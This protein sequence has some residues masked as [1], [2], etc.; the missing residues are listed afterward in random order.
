MAV[1]DRAPAVAPEGTLDPAEYADLLTLLHRGRSSGMLTIFRG[2]AA[3]KVYFGSG[4][5]VFGSSN[6]P[7]DRLGDLLLAN[8]LISREQYDESSRLIVET[9]L[10]QGTI[11]VQLGAIDPKELFRG[12]IMQVTAIAESPFLWSDARYRY[13]PEYR[14]ED[15]MIV[16]K[17]HPG[18]LIRE[19]LWRIPPTDDLLVLAERRFRPADDCPFPAD[20]VALSPLDRKIVSAIPEEKTPAEVATW[21]G[22]PLRVVVK[23]F[24]VL[25]RLGFIAPVDAVQPASEASGPAPSDDA[26]Y[27]S[28]VLLFHQRLAGMSHYQVLGLDRAA[29]M[30]DIKGAYIGRA[31]E[32]HPDR[33]HRETLADIAPAAGEIFVRVNEAFNTLSDDNR[34]RHYDLSLSES[35]RFPAPAR[36]DDPAMASEQAR[37]GLRLLRCGEFREAADAFRWAVRLAPAKASYHACLAQAILQT[38]RRL[39][40]AEEHCRMAIGLDP[41]NAAYYVTLGLVYKRGKVADR[42]VEVFRKALRLDPGNATARRELDELEKAPGGRKADQTASILGRFFGKS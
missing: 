19:G 3:K 30:A 1:T 13:E 40:E 37:K 22:I 32:Y 6:Q 4:Q 10:K 18:A 2:P 12:L 14:R 36:T 35:G 28:A 21:T 7:E 34:R 42:A 41:S 25:A 15:Q 33:F 5:V 26:D 29:T 31:K 20:E 11:L 9:K 39:K 8:G 17:L 23:S 38:G 24:D 27:R 16:L